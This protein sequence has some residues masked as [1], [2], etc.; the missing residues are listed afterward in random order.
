VSQPDLE[1]TGTAGSDVRVPPAVSATNF[2]AARVETQ[3]LGYRR[4]VARASLEDAEEQHQE[5]YFN[6]WALRTGQRG[7]T[8]PAELLRQLGDLGFA[9]RDVARLLGVSVQA[10][11]KW[12][13]GESV[14]GIRRRQIA[15][16]LAAC[17]LIREHDG[18]EEVASWFEMPLNDS[19]ITPFDLWIGG[20]YDLVFEAASD[21]VDEESILTA[22]D[23]QWR[24]R[25]ASNFEVFRAADGKLAL[26]P[27]DG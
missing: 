4:K 21:Q 12:R 5:G 14:T 25:Y 17:D 3:E 7:K 23:P 22:F 24:E 1:D 2:A 9:W 13:R 8:A 20:R 16:L 19:P 26:R 10:L 11:Q 6:E 15:S 18:I 27:K